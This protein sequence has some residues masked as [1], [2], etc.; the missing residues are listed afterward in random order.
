MKKYLPLFTLLVVLALALSFTLPLI[1]QEDAPM[2]TGLRPDAP[3]LCCAR[4]LLGWNTRIC[5]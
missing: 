4:G 3:R 1:A 2:R 5:D